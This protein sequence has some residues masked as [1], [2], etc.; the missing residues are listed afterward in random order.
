MVRAMSIER[1][2]LGG[3][4]ALESR[5]AATR[6]LLRELVIPEGSELGGSLWVGAARLVEDEEMARVAKMREELEG[7]FMLV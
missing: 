5:R 1:C 7:I 4:T 6:W 3:R 2:M